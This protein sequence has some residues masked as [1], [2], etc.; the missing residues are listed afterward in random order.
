MSALGHKQTF[1]VQD[2]MSALPPKADMCGA[3]RY[4][5]YVPKEDSKNIATIKKD[6]LAA[7]SP[8]IPSRLL[9]LSSAAL[10]MLHQDL[11]SDRH[12]RVKICD[13][14]VDQPEAA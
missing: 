7:A 4:V 9:P 11:G 5:R 12:A 8:K 6:R 14:V 10:L 1:A 13:I 2:V 3:T